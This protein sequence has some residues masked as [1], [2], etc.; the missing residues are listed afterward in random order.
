MQLYIV[1]MSLSINCSDYLSWHVVKTLNSA[2]DGCLGLK[3]WK[4]FPIG[5]D[6]FGHALDLQSLSYSWMQQFSA[7]SCLMFKFSSFMTA[8]SRYRQHYLNVGRNINPSYGFR[9]LSRRKMLLVKNLFTNGQYLFYSCIIF[10]PIQSRQWTV[11]RVLTAKLM[12]MISNLNKLKQIIRYSFN[13]I[14]KQVKW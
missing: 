5:C 10:W 9:F 14:D 2:T 1:K 13:R 8:D 6:M 3:G 7:L 12:T 11:K 4:F